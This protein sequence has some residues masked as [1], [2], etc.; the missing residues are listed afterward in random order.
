WSTLASGAGAIT[1]GALAQLDPALFANG[2]YSLRL[3]A[4]DV[5][6]RTA[7]AETQVEIDSIKTLPR[8]ETDFTVTLA[9]HQIAL[10]RHYDPLVRAQAGSFGNGWQLALKDVAIETDVAPTGR[11]AFGSYGAFRNGTRVY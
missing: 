10:V 3:T 9:G 4:A 11:E 6:G 5:A 2:V 1:N 7:R 8:A